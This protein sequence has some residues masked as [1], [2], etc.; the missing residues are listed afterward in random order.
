MPV[1]RGPQ[2]NARSAILVGV[3][4]V[5]IAVL[6]AIAVLWLADS[7]GNVEVN[8]GD[9]DF[10]DLDA[11]RISAE[12]ADGGPILFS[13]VAGG[14]RD[15]ILQHLGDDPTI[16]WLAF[17]ARRPGDA[18]DCFFEWQVDTETFVN[19]CDETDV[20][21]ASGTGLNQYP[22]R[23]ENGEVRVDINAES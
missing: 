2:V 16:G 10:R 21:D 9:S 18:R 23:V 4:G 20:V 5:V 11:G 3:T 1:A 12:I 15:L 7:G 14:D 13:D 19:T 22:V 17:E 6:L 8:L